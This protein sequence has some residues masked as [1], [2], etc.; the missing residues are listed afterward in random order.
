MKKALSIILAFVLLCFSAI[1]CTYAEEVMDED[2]ATEDELFEDPFY[3]VMSSGET[4]TDDTIVEVPAT[5]ETDTDI[6][7][8]PDT[9]TELEQP[10]EA[11]PA[12]VYEKEVAVLQ[13]LGILDADDYTITITRAEFVASVAVLCGYTGEAQSA[14][15]Y[16]SDV[17]SGHAGEGA[18]AYAAGIKLVQGDGA[19]FRPNDSITVEEAGFI[20]LRALG[21]DS[22]SPYVTIDMA[23][24]KQ[25]GIFEGISAN[26]KSPLTFDA[27][28]K[29]IYNA[30][31]LEMILVRGTT[32]DGFG[33]AMKLEKD[34]TTL[35]NYYL[36]IYMTEGRVTDNGCSAIYGES[37]NS[38]VNIKIDDVLFEKGEVD[39]TD[40]LGYE[41]EAYYNEENVLLCV[42]DITKEKDVVHIPAENIISAVLGNVQYEN[43]SGKIRN[44]SFPL[45]ANIIYNGKTL[46]PDEYNDELLNPD[47][48]NIKLIRTTGSDYNL[49][50]I[51]SEYN[52]VVNKI[53]ET[54]NT[55]TIIDT[56]SKDKNV[57]FDINDLGYK[58]RITDASGNSV[59]YKDI[60]QYNILSVAKSLDG[61]L[62][63]IKVSTSKT[64][65]IIES[66]SN[67]GNMVITV[68]GMQYTIAPGA[69]TA[70]IAVDTY[71]D[72][73]F[74]IYGNVAYFNSY[75]K[76]EKRYGYI[77]KVKSLE[78]D[79]PTLVVKIFDPIRQVLTFTAQKRIIVD[80]ITVKDS[81]FTALAD[82]FYA[83]DE[84]QPCLVRY[85][86]NLDGS[87]KSIDT[88]T[89]TSA[90]TDNSLRRIEASKPLQYSSSM[91]DGFVRYELTPYM[92]DGQMFVD[93]NAIVFGV[94]RGTHDDGDYQIFT[95]NYFQNNRY[96]DV[97]L[98]TDE[99]YSN[100]AKAV[101]VK[102]SPKYE[103]TLQNAKGYV[104]LPS[105]HGSGM[106]TGV[107]TDVWVAVDDK[108]E[109][110]NQVEITDLLSGAS[111][112]YSLR[113]EEQATNL[114]QGMVVRYFSLDHVRIIDIE[115]VFDLNTRTA[116]TPRDLRPVQNMKT[117]YVRQNGRDLA[118]NS[119]TEA[120][121]SNIY[122]AWQLTYLD[123]LSLKN[124]MFTGVAGDASVNWNEE[125][126]DRALTSR[127]SYV[128]KY[129]RVIKE[130]TRAS[131]NDISGYDEAG[132]NCS[133]V[134]ALY[135]TAALR[136]LIILD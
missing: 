27:A 111:N 46:N 13:A 80:G 129:D 121:T 102:Y 114:C 76:Y 49:I 50:V 74:D 82:S 19:N 1:P 44:V 12:L 134:V 58:V 90:E 85:E 39:V 25:E 83:G 103:S 15:A 108:G 106:N 98:Y 124:G 47:I 133:K 95:R 123:V 117:F 122:P 6:I 70:F 113:W 87:L 136:S 5:D 3:D 48:G 14:D 55:V 54:N 51:T 78:D 96:Y 79:I 135:R 77:T 37:L 69:D 36:K 59:S 22:F 38:H 53:N 128:F 99:P 88:A 18:I 100:I 107:V 84:F 97:E 104:L 28:A 21:Y 7:V 91:F 57:S 45:T 112:T 9:M 94:P 65:G 68:S 56:D 40:L 4:V 93:Q 75:A 24:A 60:S 126:V 116:M 119:N 52:S 61:E 33:T 64:G 30:M 23:K 101:V 34:G 67:S 81:G 16:F 72:L 17:P 71:G 11:E 132:D 62:I 20:L 115:P 8:V 125:Y 29:A 43:E 66:I 131:L 89:C 26:G 110:V 63:S 118:D 35:L 31:N 130:L 10:E 120:N 73:H 105:L 32:S 127:V 92:F 42:C 41:V 86:L 109:V 2:I